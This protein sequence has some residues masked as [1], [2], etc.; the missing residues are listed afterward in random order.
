VSS[1]TV[2]RWLRS[3]EAAALNALHEPILDALKSR[4]EEAGRIAVLHHH[5]V[6]EQHLAESH[7]EHGQ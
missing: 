7:R 2:P 6:M 1:G 5:Y 3:S 4:D